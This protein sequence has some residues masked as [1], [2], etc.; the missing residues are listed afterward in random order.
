MPRRQPCREYLVPV[1]AG[2]IGWCHT[3]FV[4]KSTN[5][6]IAVS[7]GSSLQDLRAV[8]AA[9]LGGSCSHERVCEAVHQALE[10]DTPASDVYC[11]HATGSLCEA[12]YNGYY[13]GM[14]S[15]DRVETILFAVQRWRGVTV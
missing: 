3:C 10:S 13:D 8:I 7:R 9:N 12:V 11:C 1:P 4:P 5:G 14:N 6:V 2:T 15:G